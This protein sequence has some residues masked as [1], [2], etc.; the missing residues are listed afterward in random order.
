MTVLV[1]IHDCLGKLQHIL[2]KAFVVGLECAS[3]YSWR[4]AAQGTKFDF[5]RDLPDSKASS[6]SH[7]RSQIVVT[8]SKLL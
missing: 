7:F 4:A 1:R 5:A 6:T 2:E 3:I 8:S